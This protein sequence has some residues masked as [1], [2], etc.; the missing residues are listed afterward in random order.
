MKLLDTILTCSSVLLLQCL[1]MFWKALPPR[2]EIEN[3]LFDWSEVESKLLS[4]SN[5]IYSCY[6][7]ES[8]FIHNRS[9]EL[10]SK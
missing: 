6:D 10:L 7:L 9:L 1:D 5:K 8:A 3:V 2:Q 4:S